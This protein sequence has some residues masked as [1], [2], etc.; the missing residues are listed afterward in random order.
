M[1]DQDWLLAEELHW[2]EITLVPDEELCRDASAQLVL[3]DARGVW[4]AFSP[5]ER[6]PTLYHVPVNF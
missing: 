1:V 6:A 4:V 2:Y 3:F 5:E